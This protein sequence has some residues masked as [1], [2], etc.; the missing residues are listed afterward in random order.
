[1]TPTVFFRRGHEICRAY[2]H[3]RF[4]TDPPKTAPA[5]TGCGSARRWASS[6]GSKTRASRHKAARSNLQPLFG[7]PGGLQYLRAELG[8]ARSSRPRPSRLSMKGLR[9]PLHVGTTGKNREGVRKYRRFPRDSEAPVS[10]SGSFSPLSAPATF[11]QRGR[12]VTFRAVKSGAKKFH[13]RPPFIVLS[14]NDGAFR[15]IL[16]ETARK[17][18]VFT[19]AVRGDFR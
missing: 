13:A 19:P 16:S 15:P 11:S 8:K 2:P 7:E 9:Y 4:C 17:I 10:A 18:G 5:E 1:M 12:G 14:R 6:R 3:P